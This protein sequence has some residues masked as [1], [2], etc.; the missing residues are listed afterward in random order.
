MSKITIRHQVPQRPTK[1]ECYEERRSNALWWQQHRTRQRFLV[2][3]QYASKYAMS[4]KMEWHTKADFVPSVLKKIMQICKAVESGERRYPEDPKSSMPGFAVGE[5][6]ED[7]AETKVTGEN[8]LSTQIL[9]LDIDEVPGYVSHIERWLPS[10]LPPNV[11]ALW[12]STPR[13]RECTKRIRVVIPLNRPISMAEKLSMATRLPIPGADP[14]SFCAAK[15]SLLPCWCK[16]TVDFH[17]GIVGN[18]MLKPD[19]DLKPYV[20]PRT[21]PKLHE[22]YRLQTTREVSEALSKLVE[23]INEAPDGH[24]QEVIKPGLAKIFRKYDVHYSECEE[25]ANYIERNDR[26]KDFLGIARWLDNRYKR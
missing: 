11:F 10:V 22:I 14:A 15:F 8:F 24:S 3:P 4:D 18:R 9:V 20:A 2:K 23:K 7:F 26:V 13:W 21:P 6:K 16:D 19:G 25:F 17:W 1:S 5:V 12:Y